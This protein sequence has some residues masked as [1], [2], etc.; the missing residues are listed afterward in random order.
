[1]ADERWAGRYEVKEE[2][3]WVKTNQLQRIIRT[4]RTG[5]W[6]NHSK[7]HCLVGYKG[8]PPINRQLDC[9]VVVA[10]ASRLKPPRQNSA[11]P[12]FELSTQRWRRP[13][14]AWRHWACGLSVAVHVH[15]GLGPHWLQVRETSRKPDELYGL[16]DRYF[17]FT[18]QWL[19]FC[20][21]HLS[22][23]FLDVN[24]LL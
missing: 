15:W 16:L 8:N 19:V 1:M 17:F 7:E 18:W 11:V 5:H 22:C 4:G 21:C 6:I 12:F 9:D 24:N 20:C 10:G 2:L 3:I 23:V 14:E 13:V